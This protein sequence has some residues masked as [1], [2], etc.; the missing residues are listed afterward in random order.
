MNEWMN[1]WSI[2]QSIKYNR[3]TSALIQA[4]Y[5]LRHFCLSVCLFV[6]L[7]VTILYCVEMAKHVIK[8]ISLSYSL[9]VLFVSYRM[10]L[11]MCDDMRELTCI[12]KLTEVE[13]SGNVFFNRIPSHSQWFIPIPNPKFVTTFPFSP[14]PIPVSHQM[15][16]QLLLNCKKIVY[17]R[18][19]FFYTIQNTMTSEFAVAAFIDFHACGFVLVGLKLH[20]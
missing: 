14:A 12:E 11:T 4:Q 15:Q 16:M 5:L 8:L 2:N 1:E 3:S 7:S 9:I 10:S 6:C 13:M 19:L 18:Y 20:K 17:K